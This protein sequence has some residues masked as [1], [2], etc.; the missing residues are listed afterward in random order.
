MKM[1][2]SPLRGD[3]FINFAFCILIFDLSSPCKR[4]GA[5]SGGAN[6]AYKGPGPASPT[7][8]ATC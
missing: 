2:E 5:V 3:D 8:T 1:A 6:Q 7:R 4:D